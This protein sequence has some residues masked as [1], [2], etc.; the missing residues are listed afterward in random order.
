METLQRAVKNW[1]AQKM[2][3]RLL[4]CQL[5][6]GIPGAL[7]LP[8]LRRAPQRSRAL[9]ICHGDARSGVTIAVWWSPTPL[10]DEPISWTLSSASIVRAVMQPGT[11]RRRRLPY[12]SRRPRASTPRP[13][14]PLRRPRR[15]QSVRIRPTTPPP[16]S[17]TALRSPSLS[18]PAS[19]SPATD[20]TATTP[21]SDFSTAPHR[22]T[23]SP[24]RIATSSPSP[25]GS[26]SPRPPA[27]A[28]RPGPSASPTPPCAPI[29]RRTRPSGD[30]PPH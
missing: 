21:S 22:P 28:A 11:Y 24:R 30:R 3:R 16:S 9:A 7:W 15:T 5:C 14:L 18:R 10:I 27:A 6:N 20:P 12:G 13:P 1:L 2:L 26:G 25:P 23:S 17:G 4:R 19:R 29:P 8:W